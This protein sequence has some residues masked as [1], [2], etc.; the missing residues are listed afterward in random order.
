MLDLGPVLE[1]FGDTAAA[2]SQLDLVICVDTAVAHLAG[3]LG[4]PVWIM[5]PEIGDFR[6]LLDRE[7]SPWYPTMRLFR[8]RKLGEWGEVVA[9]V[10]E[11]LEEAVRTGSPVPST[12]PPRSGQYRQPSSEGVEAT[13]DTVCMGGNANGD[14]SRC[15]GALWN[16]SIFA[17]W[18]R[19]ARSIAWYGEFLQPHLDLLARLIGP[20]D[21]LVEVGSGIGA[22]A[23]PL[24]KMLGAKGHIF[25]YETR[26][27][28]A[29]HTAAESRC[30]SSCTANHADAASPLGSS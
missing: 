1:D 13:I 17:E 21:H 7:D 14:F 18:R 29:T 5:L 26:P 4:K 22:H 11:A 30:K 24:A 6:W 8:Q 9:R 23:I 2:I 19:T 28:I 3:A 25:L 27:I 16:R 12:A 10:K 15:G 20:D